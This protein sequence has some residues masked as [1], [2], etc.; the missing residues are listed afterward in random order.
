M[1]INKLIEDL[2]SLIERYHNDEFWLIPS[3]ERMLCVAIL[4][5][6][7]D[8]NIR[9]EELDEELN[10]N[11]VSEAVGLNFS[12]ILKENYWPDTILFKEDHEE[13][14][15]DYFSFINLIPDYF[16]ANDK[17]RR[18]KDTQVESLKSAFHQFLDEEKLSFGVMAHALNEAISKMKSLLADIKRKIDNP[19]SYVYRKVWDE[20]YDAYKDEGIDDEFNR[21]LNDRSKVDVAILQKKQLCE[22]YEMMKSKFFRYSDRPSI[23]EVKNCL[24][25]RNEDSLPAGTKRSDEIKEECARFE[26]FF[27]L[28]KDL[29]FTLDYEMLGRYITL[30]GAKFKDEEYVGLVDFDVMM[31]CINE[32]MA[33]VRPNLKVY[34]KNYEGNKVSEILAY[35]TPILNSCQKY[36]RDDLR[37]TILREFLTK[38][39][40]DGEIK[41]YL[42]ERLGNS[43]LRNKCLCLIIAALDLHRIFRVDAVSEDLAKTLSKAFD[44]KP[45]ASSITHYI[46]DYRSDHTKDKIYLWTKRNIEDLKAHP[47]NV[48]Y[49]I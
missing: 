14:K 8:I 35:G 12:E 20:L 17:E 29:I 16:T 33:S 6:L 40:H 28:K 4:C 5:Q 25:L 9:L 22:I 11:I 39:L 15:R 45:S 1:Y 3:S 48:F 26:K 42:V 10:H 49:G 37:N 21:W 19:H 18:F 27:S 24:L 36:L 30:N 46:N 34:L 47:Y 31:D 44:G 32:E 38:A 2:R 13:N 43:R 23:G 7:H 41:N